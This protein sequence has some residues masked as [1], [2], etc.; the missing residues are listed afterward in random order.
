MGLAR[1][2]WRGLTDALSPWD[3]EGPH[4][5]WRIWKDKYRQRMM[6]RVRMRLSSAS[7]ILHAVI[8]VIVMPRAR[9]GSNM[10]ADAFLCSTRIQAAA[11]L[12]A[13]YKF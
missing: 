5:S 1:L 10:R 8:F 3:A 4:R 13:A 9:V 12:S 6:T 7:L 2:P 11:R